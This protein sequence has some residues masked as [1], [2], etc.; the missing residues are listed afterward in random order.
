MRN[1]LFGAFCVL[2]VGGCEGAAGPDERPGVEPSA[3]QALGLD[4]REGHPRGCIPSEVDDCGIEEPQEGC[5]PNEV[6]D[7]GV[8]LQSGCIP[9]EVDDCG[10]QEPQ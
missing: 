1:V 9:C 4:A 3:V 2:L 7:C 10:I 8:E 5:I 6:Y